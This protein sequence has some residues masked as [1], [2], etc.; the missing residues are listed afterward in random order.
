MLY[1]PSHWRFA[2]LLM[3]HLQRKSGHLART[4]GG[5]LAKCIVCQ[6]G[7]RDC[8][9]FSSGAFI[10]KPDYEITISGVAAGSSP[11]LSCTGCNSFFNRTITLSCGDS[12]EQPDGFSKSVICGPST[13]VPTCGLHSGERYGVLGYIR[14]Y[15]TAVDI[16]V[17]LYCIT[18]YV[19]LFGYN[20]TGGSSQSKIAKLVFDNRTCGEHTQE[21]Q[22]CTTSRDPDVSVVGP[23]ACTETDD[24]ACGVASATVS[25]TA[26]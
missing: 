7:K 26:L 14:A 13:P 16:T 15:Y 10:D 9:C 19:H 1:L 11:Y 5:H 17:N 6:E 25:F 20:E 23:G 12:Y 4:S 3:G 22:L 18:G 2:P 8:E 21:G 24:M